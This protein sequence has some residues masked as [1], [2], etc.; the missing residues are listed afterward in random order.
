MFKKNR[1]LF[2]KKPHLF[3]DRY[4]LA[5]FLLNT[6]LNIQTEWFRFCKCKRYEICLVCQAKSCYEDFQY[7]I[8]E[9]SLDLN[10]LTKITENLYKNM[11]KLLTLDKHFVCHIMNKK[12][13]HYHRDWFTGQKNEYDIEVCSGTH[14]QTIINK[15]CS[16]NCK[17]VL[18]SI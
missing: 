7:Q 15:I 3:E 16:N 2:E 17:V 18:K 10:Y 1:D 8:Y 13:K 6:I 5:V 9:H 4:H 11:L 12:Y 14:E